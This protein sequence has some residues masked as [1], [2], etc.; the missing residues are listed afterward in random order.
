MFIFLYNPI[1]TT[2]AKDLANSKSSS[3][4]LLSTK[5]TLYTVHP[6][7]SREWSGREE[8]IAPAWYLTPHSSMT[9]RKLPNNILERGS[10]NLPTNH[11]AA[12]ACWSV[13]ESWMLVAISLLPELFYHDFTSTIPNVCA[14][15]EGKLNMWGKSNM[16]D[17]K[18]KMLYWKI[19]KR[20]KR[21]IIRMRANIT[22]QIW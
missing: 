20:G 8:K 15:F 5:A 13:D 14:K 17:E 4:S 1:W 11:R 12:Y 10:P 21:F 9:C 6:H 18:R 3:L 7:D 16:T 2:G 19:F 22:L